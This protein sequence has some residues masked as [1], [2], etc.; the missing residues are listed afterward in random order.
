MGRKLAFYHIF[1]TPGTPAI[2]SD[3]IQK[4]H[5]SGCYGALDTI[6]CFLAG[7]NQQMIDVVK[8]IIQKSGAKFV[9]SAEGPGDRSYERFTL[10]R[11]ITMIE[12]QDKVLYFH[13]KSITKLGNPNVQDWRSFLEYMTFTK[14]QDALELLDTYDTVGVNYNYHPKHHYSGNF[15]W[16]T[17]KYLLRLPKEI[18]HDYWAPEF[19]IGF[20]QPKA[21]QLFNSK[22]DHYKSAYAFKEYVDVDMLKDPSRLRR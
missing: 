22:V 20:G 15:W 17:G 1:C 12:P 14:H 11:M 18:H 6:Y 3:Q 19:W 8:A 21:Y 16:A 13:S 5:F 2:V 10:L 7:Q 9:V 4:L